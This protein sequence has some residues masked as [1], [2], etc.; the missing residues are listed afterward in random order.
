MSYRYL[1]DTAIAD[2]AFE[3][4]GRT[5]EE[6]FRAAGDALMNL[7]VENI[8]SIG[9]KKNST[10]AVDDFDMDMLLFKFLDELIFNKDAHALL[11][12]IESIIIAK[13][14]GRFLA[15]ADA[16]GE[17]IDPGKHHL[18][19]DVK[20]V[21]LYDFALTQTGNTWTAHVHVDI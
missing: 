3:A 9:R 16:W 18:N 20:A 15:T 11:L 6:V 17:K 1:S 12:R 8:D 2:A 21:T 13:R 10:I 19:V 7:M 5:P 4:S 14:E